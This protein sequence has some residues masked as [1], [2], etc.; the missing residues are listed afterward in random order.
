MKSISGH[1]VPFAVLGHPIGHTLSPVMH[2]ASIA[3]LGLDAVY[4]AFDTAPERLME[5]LP[6]FKELGF[7]GLNLTV[8][9]KEVAF[10]GFQA[11]LAGGSLAESAALAGAVNTVEFTEAGMVGHTTDG[12]G[13]LRALKEAFGAGIGPGERVFVLGCGGAGRTVALAAASMSPGTLLLSD[14]D[15][16]RVSRLRSDLQRYAPQVETV[17]VGAAE[18]MEACRSAKWVLQASPVGM[19][20]EDPVL[21]PPEAFEPGQRLFDLIY[22]Y[23]ETAL[24]RRAREQGAQVA[25]GLGMLLHQGARSFEIWTGRNPD[26][27][28]MR[29]ALEEAVYGTEAG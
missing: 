15:P 10:K 17:A 2:N 11:G 1:T 8:P 29:R 18:Q 28:A 16:D 5:L 27:V 4:L 13:F 19:R 25:N 26:T 23:P 6:V 24:M 7:G 22:M 9:L 14:A 21:L 3:A 20:K 12:I